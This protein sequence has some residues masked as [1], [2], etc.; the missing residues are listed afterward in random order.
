MSDSSEINVSKMKPT[1]VIGFGG[2]GIKTLLRL[3]KLVWERAPQILEQN[4]LICLGLDTEPWTEAKH[5]DKATGVELANN[6]EY[7]SLA[8]GVDID[9]WVKTEFASYLKDKSDVGIAPQWP[10]INGMCYD[11]ALGEKITNG[12]AQNRPVGRACVYNS[13]AALINKLKGVMDNFHSIA[14]AGTVTSKDPTVH[15]IGS[16]AGGTGSSMIFDIPYITR[17]ICGQGNYKSFGHFPLANAFLNDLPGEWETIRCRANTWTVLKEIDHWNRLFVSDPGASHWKVNYGYDCGT[18]KNGVPTGIAKQRPVDVTFL[19]HNK[20]TGGNVL[21]SA[22][23]LYEI[24]AQSIGYIVISDLIGS[25]DSNLVNVKNEIRTLNSKDKVKAYSALGVATLDLPV[26]RLKSYMGYKWAKQLAL[27][28]CAADVHAPEEEFDSKKWEE[29]G[30]LLEKVF[31]LQFPAW[32]KGDDN[33]WEESDTATLREQWGEL[34]EAYG[35]EKL[36][37]DVDSRITSRILDNYDNRI[38]RATDYYR[39]CESEEVAHEKKQETRAREKLDEIKQG[40]KD[41]MTGVMNGKRSTDALLFATPLVVRAIGKVDQ[42]LSG[43]QES[44]QGNEARLATSSIPATKL[45][46]SPWFNSGRETQVKNWARDNDEYW[47]QKAESDRVVRLRAN[48]KVIGEF[49][50]EMKAMVHEADKTAEL[51]A[52]DCEGEAEQEI[53]NAVSEEVA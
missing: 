14:K 26:D 51:F 19:Y 37:L 50:E 36:D 20:N 27:D 22:A 33:R 1:I 41:Y 45:K 10:I 9:Q 23:P 47:I 11:P 3:K 35:M 5:K 7:I 16:I 18:M 15:F 43:V 25:L 32:R 34:A 28:N 52:L 4:K 53:Q 40:I 39:D 38:Q 42:L 49:L 8:V 6:K 48:L 24:M 46:E 29:F 17:I 2:T 12:A 13:A 44:T 31:T 21:S 30:G